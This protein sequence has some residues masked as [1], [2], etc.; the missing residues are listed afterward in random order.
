[1]LRRL[2]PLLVAVLGVAGMELFAT[3]ATVEAECARCSRKGPC[4]TTPHMGGWDCT[5][6]PGGCAEVGGCGYGPTYNPAPGSGEPEEGRPLT[7]QSTL[8]TRPIVTLAEVMDDRDG[9][10]RL[11]PTGA[12]IPVPTA[13]ATCSI[14][15][16]RSSLAGCKSHWESGSR[17]IRQVAPVERHLAAAAVGP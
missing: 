13:I 15:N 12:C 14:P 5:Y 2:S 6:G 17:M 9:D 1:M 7:A 10:P 8:A 16:G 11:H 4:L 3:S